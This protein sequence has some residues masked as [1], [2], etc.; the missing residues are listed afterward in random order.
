MRLDAIGKRY[1]PRGPWVLRDVSLELTPGQLVRAE[2]GNGSGKSTLLRIVAGAQAP[3]R[4]R[5]HRLPARRAYV[6]E[7]FPGELPLTARDY[8]HHL[9]RIRGLRGRA[10]HARAAELL[11]RFG[12][13]E[14][15][16]RALPELSKGTCQKV[17]V[18]QALLSAVDLLVLDE[19]WTG[20]DRSARAELDTAVAEC[21]DEGATVVFVDHDPD[22]LG[23]FTAARWRVERGGV[24][25]SAAAAPTRRIVFHGSAD[26]L[27]AVPGVLAV[28][29]RGPRAVVVTV[30]SAHSDA[31]L[32]HLLRDPD[33]Q[34]ESVR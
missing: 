26:G 25:E 31:V 10:V 4:G 27:V 34:V 1:G 20:L 13:A 6:P 5:V 28:E 9:G 32:R 3:T 18:A 8:L 30:E 22:R 23:R 33:N 2:G 19:A 15:A 29:S 14:H 24:R 12:A 11:E 21:L 16:D 17:A 7:R